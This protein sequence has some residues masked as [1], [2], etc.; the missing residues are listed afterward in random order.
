M[1]TPALRATP[2]QRGMG[3]ENT[4]RRQTVNEGQ[5]VSKTDLRKMQDN[6]A[7]G[8]NP[9]DLRKPKTQTTSR[10]SYLNR[11]IIMAKLG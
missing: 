3:S 11:T 10:L 4:Q 1:T 8:C 9:R 7:Q 2:P 6:K 5:T